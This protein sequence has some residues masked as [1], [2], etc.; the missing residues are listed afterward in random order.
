M[1][2]IRS[3]P[4]TSRGRIDDATMCGLWD[5]DELAGKAARSDVMAT[6]TVGRLGTC[7]SWL[8]VNGHG[9]WMSSSSATRCACEIDGTWYGFT[10]RRGTVRPPWGETD[11]VPRQ[12]HLAG[13]RSGGDLAE[14]SL[15]R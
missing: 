1:G 8:N 11:V 3:R 5:S 9:W 10:L 4:H 15:S 13:W 12:E 7:A 14:W 2:A 6:L